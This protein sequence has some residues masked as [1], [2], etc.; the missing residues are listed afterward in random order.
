MRPPFLYPVWLA[1]LLGLAGVPSL[2]DEPDEATTQPPGEARVPD[3]EV[4]RESQ[5]GVDVEAF[6]GPLEQIVA[7]GVSV[8]VLEPSKY[9]LFGASSAA[10]LLEQ[11]RK[12]GERGYRFQGVSGT[13]KAFGGS[14]VVAIMSRPSD[15]SPQRRFEYEILVAKETSLMQE[16]LSAAGKAGFS[17]RD[18]VVFDNVAKDRELVTILERERGTGRARFEYRLLAIHQLTTMRTRL[19]EADAAGFEFVGLITGLT[20]QGSVETV[21]VMRRDAPD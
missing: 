16:E 10:T 20:R 2:E 19:Q 18:Q 6:T 21:C 7:A 9:V 14:G 8:T 1:L 17:L 4:E 5:F 3:P 15:A 12:S 13:E 11:M